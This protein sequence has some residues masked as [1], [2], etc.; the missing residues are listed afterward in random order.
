MKIILKLIM[1]CRLIRFCYLT[2]NIS[3]AVANNFILNS[4]I[5]YVMNVIEDVYGLIDVIGPCGTVEAVNREAGVEGW[6]CDGV[7]RAFRR[8]TATFPFESQELSAHGA[9]GPTPTPKEVLCLNNHKKTS[10]IDDLRKSMRHFQHSR[11]IKNA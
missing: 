9:L 5:T 11:P 2:L 7:L 6:C 3:T 8:A 1:L 10:L 4:G